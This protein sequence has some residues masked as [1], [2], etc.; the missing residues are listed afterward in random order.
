MTS[1][2]AFTGVLAGTLAWITLPLLPA[3]REL[4]RPRDAGPLDAVGQDSG[5]LTFFADSFRHFVHQGGHAASTAGTLLPDGRRIALLSAADPAPAVD[6]GTGL[7]VAQAG[8]SLPESTEC[9]VEIYGTGDLG[10]G[11]GSSVRAAF[12]EGQLTLSSRATILRWVHG[13]R[14]LAVGDETHLLGRATSR[15]AVA[16]GRGVLFDRILAP[17]IVVGEASIAPTSL[18]R[19]AWELH[20]ARPQFNL[21][22][23]S[24]ILAP[25]HWLVDGNLTLPDGHV[26]RGSLVVRGAL[27]VGAGCEIRGSVKAHKMLTVGKKAVITGTAASR[28]DILLDEDA[29][30]YGPVISEGTVTLAARARVGLPSMPASVSADR[31]ALHRG[32]EVFGSLSARIAGSTAED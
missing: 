4:M 11:T 29:R 17:Y 22:H 32:A 7:L 6:K 20:D 27:R 2:L 19:D 31:I 1:A 13:E 8:T 5:D 16:L 15:G 3:I 28:N 21:P 10:I 14:A 23:A 25:Q 30:V 18:S 9:P 12:A 26:F 24:A